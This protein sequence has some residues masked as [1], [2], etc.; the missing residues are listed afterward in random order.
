M[1]MLFQSFYIISHLIQCVTCGVFVKIK[2]ML[3][4][5]TKIAADLL[6]WSWEGCDQLGHDG[7]DFRVTLVQMFGQRAHEDDHALPHGVVAGVLRRVL[8]KLLKHGQQRVHVVLRDR[9]NIREWALVQEDEAGRGIWRRST[10]PCVLR[11]D[12][13]AS[14]MQRRTSACLSFRASGTKNRKRGVTW[15]SSRNSANLFSARAM[16]HLHI[17]NASLTNPLHGGNWY[18]TRNAL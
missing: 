1:K 5:Q 7:F 6:W 14:S 11:A 8:Q 17:G 16:P 12:S 15:L 10:L 9:N 3:I 18:M 4:M 13:A 2:S